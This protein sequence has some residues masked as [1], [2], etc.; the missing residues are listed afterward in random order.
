MVIAGDEQVAPLRHQR[1]NVCERVNAGLCCKVL[2]VAKTGTSA[3]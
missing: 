2:L 3:V 1:V